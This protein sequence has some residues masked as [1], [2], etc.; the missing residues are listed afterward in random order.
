MPSMPESPIVQPAKPS[1][2]PSARSASFAGNS[3]CTMLLPISPPF[4]RTLYAPPMFRAIVLYEGEAPEPDRYRQ[5]VEDFVSKVPGATFR[6]GTV[7]GAAVGEPR[8]AYY[9]EFE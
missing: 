6:H 8:F 1:Q 9:A 7:L 2:K 5:H 4:S 3:T